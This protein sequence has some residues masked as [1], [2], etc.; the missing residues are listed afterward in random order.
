MLPARNSSTKMLA[1]IRRLMRTALWNHAEINA[2]TWLT[3]TGGTRNSIIQIKTCD[4]TAWWMAEAPEHPGRRKDECLQAGVFLLL[5]LLHYGFLFI[6]THVEDRGW[7]EQ[8]SVSCSFAVW[9]WCCSRSQPLCSRRPLG[10]RSGNPRRRTPSNRTWSSRQ[11]CWRGSDGSS[12]PFCKR[13][14]KL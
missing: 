5:L 9:P 7:A 13:R 11:K 6:N 2:A 10:F 14:L 4:M 1:N 3:L 12:L 8:S